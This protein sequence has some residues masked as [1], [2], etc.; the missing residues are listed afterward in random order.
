MSHLVYRHDAATFYI[1]ITVQY[2]NGQKGCGRMLANSK[3]LE[4]IETLSE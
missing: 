2:E 4:K 1:I 3:M